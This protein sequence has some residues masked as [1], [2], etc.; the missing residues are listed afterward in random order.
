M[1]SGF[2]TLAIPKEMYIGKFQEQKKKKANWEPRD[3]ISFCMEQ[4]FI[5]NKT[6]KI[7][8]SDKVKINSRN[9]LIRVFEYANKQLRRAG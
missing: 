8:I 5:I 9:D 6:N 4:K 3:L 2:L 7:V 1:R